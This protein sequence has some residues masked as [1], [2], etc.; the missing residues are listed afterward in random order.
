MPR[1]E[2]GGFE[3]RGSYHIELKY[4]IT[5]AQLRSLIAVSRSCRQWLRWECKSAGIKVGTARE[6]VRC[7][8]CN[9]MTILTKCVQQHMH[10]SN[11]STC[12]TSTMHALAGLGKRESRGRGSMPPKTQNT[13]Q[14]LFGTFLK[15]NNKTNHTC[16]STLHSFRYFI[17][18]GI[19]DN[20]HI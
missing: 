17:L 18:S 4:N 15:R 10:T 19:L 11:I 1:T 12:F 16:M 6:C 13:F 9:S 7:S 14:K 3:E 20:N 2:V 8:Q 5:D